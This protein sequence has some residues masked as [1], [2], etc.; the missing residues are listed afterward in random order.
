MRL[1]LDHLTVVD[2]GPLELV[3]AARAS[4]CDGIGL[5]LHSMEGLAPMPTYDLVVDRRLRGDLGRA[6]ADAGVSLDLAYP[7][8]IDDRTAPDALDPLIE[9]AAEL[10]AGL[11]NVLV[12]DRDPSRRLA[13]FSML[14]ERAQSYGLKVAVE[15]YPVSQVRSLSEALALTTQL[16][17]PGAVGVN[18][19]LLHL[20]RSGGSN[21]ELA[22]APAGSILFAQLADGPDHCAAPDRE[23]EAAKARLLAGQGVFD[24]AGFVNA[25]P[26]DCPLS[27][28]IP[29]N[30]QI[31][32]GVSRGPRASAAVESVRAGLA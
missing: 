17:A 4:G 27:V 24:I 22:A 31:T 10:D 21:A 12:Y 15:F 14:S 9:C 16:D 26:A 20:V 7:F 23:N 1:A 19:D 5:F 2:A 6:M 25:L 30:D 29:R 11:I 13:K 28:E 3:G 32:A 8:T 18:V